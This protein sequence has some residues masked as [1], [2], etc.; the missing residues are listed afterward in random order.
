MKIVKISVSKKNV[1]NNI[2][3]IVSKM[4]QHRDA[5]KIINIMMKIKKIKKIYTVINIIM[6]SV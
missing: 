3:N 6:N 1:L 5:D 2:K 4:K